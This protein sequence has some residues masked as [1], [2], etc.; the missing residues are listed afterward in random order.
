MFKMKQITSEREET[1]DVACDSCH[2]SCKVNSE[3]DIYEYAELS[4][5]WGYHSDGR[6]GDMSDFHLC[7]KCYERVE[8]L[9]NLPRE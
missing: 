2:T 3:P 6:D 8:E 4:M 5:S 1:V 7:Q 9:L